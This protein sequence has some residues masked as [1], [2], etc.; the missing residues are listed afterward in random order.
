[1]GTKKSCLKAWHFV[2]CLIVLEA[3]ETHLAPWHAVVSLLHT[4]LIMDL[5]QSLAKM[6]FKLMW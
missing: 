5:F 6:G 4:N 2:L 3:L 1:M